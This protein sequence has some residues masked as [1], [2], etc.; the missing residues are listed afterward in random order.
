MNSQFDNTCLC[1][2]D[3]TYSSCC[4][5][6]HLHEKSPATATLLMKSRFTAYAMHNDDYLRTTWAETKR[7][8]DINFSKDEAKW[9]RL[10]I[11][12]TKKG[13]EKD[14]KGIVEFKAYYLLDDEEYVMNEISRFQKT[15][16]RWF[17]LDGLVKSVGKVSQAQSQGK[18]APCPCGSQKKFKRCC[19][20]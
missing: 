3:L 4:Q 15:S 8:K 16:G 5:L 18:N 1:G 12:K 20:K 13:S 2:S 17:Y 19:G 9:T 10:D 6:F 14:T 11:I 7:P